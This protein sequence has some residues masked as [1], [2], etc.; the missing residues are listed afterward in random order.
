M[1]SQFRLD[2]KRV[3]VT[4]ASSGLGRAIALAVGSA[5][6]ELIVTG[7]DEE[8]LLATASTLPSG[9][10]H[11]AVTADL[12]VEADL[13]RLTREAGSVD[14]IVHAA[15]IKGPAPIRVV[16]KK[17]LDE[18][19]DSNY[20]APILLT[21]RLLV[22]S[23]IKPGGS[24]LFLSSIAAHT[25]THGMSV[26]SATKASLVV[27]AKCL[28]LEVARRAIRVNC[29]SPA[30]VRTPIFQ[31]FEEQWLNDMEQ[32]YPLGLGK[33]ED[34]ANA[35]VFFLSDASRWITGQTLIMDGACPWV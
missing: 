4:G 10:Q 8:R 25:G 34:V 16:T 13:Q 3:L 7:R 22:E 11:T 27:T 28:A 12:T 6:A 26:Y 9:P 35:S 23:R 15:G 29:V 17:F 33:P 14:G 5:G 21:Q 30:V 32:R 24:I 18:R 20:F 2:A 19:F 1:A 31:G